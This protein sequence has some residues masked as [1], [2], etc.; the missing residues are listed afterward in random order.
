MRR[1]SSPIVADGGFAFCFREAA[2]GV[3]VVGLDAVEVVL[4]LCV[5]RAEDGIGIGLAVDVRDAPLVAD[6]GGVPG[7]SFPARGFRSDERGRP[8]CR[9]TT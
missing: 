6:D 7:L 8:A 1:A 3:D 9:R 2:H 4:G 5:Y